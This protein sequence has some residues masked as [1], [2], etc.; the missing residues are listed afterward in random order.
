MHG[1][2]HQENFLFYVEEVFVD[3]STEIILQKFD[4]HPILKD[5]ACVMCHETTFMR[6][7]YYHLDD[8]ERSLPDT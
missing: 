6:S 3:L 4:F 8:S 2:L 5:T 1:A 7:F